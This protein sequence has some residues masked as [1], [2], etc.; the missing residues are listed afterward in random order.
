MIGAD[1]S[2]HRAIRADNMLWLRIS[3]RRGHTKNNQQV[4][5]YIYNW[6][7]HHPQVFQSPIANDYCYVSINGI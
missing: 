4:K 3:K 5:E 6:I 2:K 1:K 7:L